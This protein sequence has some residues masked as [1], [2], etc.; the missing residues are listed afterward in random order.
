MKLVHQDAEALRL[1]RENTPAFYVKGKVRSGKPEYNV[2]NKEYAYGSDEKN[3]PKRD[4][5]L[6]CKDRIENYSFFSWID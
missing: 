3:L 6:S 4:K 1:P 2:V 5:T